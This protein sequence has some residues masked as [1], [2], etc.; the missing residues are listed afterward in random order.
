MFTKI[1]V[2]ECIAWL[3]DNPVDFES[4]AVNC[5]GKLKHSSTSY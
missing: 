4:I 1:Q 3:E 5:I 2:K